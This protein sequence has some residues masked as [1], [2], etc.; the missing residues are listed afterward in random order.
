MKA[1]RGVR[2]GLHVL[3]IH[4]N[5]IRMKTYSAVGLTGLKAYFVIR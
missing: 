4:A 2:V 5:Y 3:S 1:D